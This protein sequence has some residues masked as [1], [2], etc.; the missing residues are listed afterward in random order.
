MNYSTIR[1]G[2]GKV[3]RDTSPNYRRNAD[4]VISKLAEFL[5][6]RIVGAILRFI[7]KSDL[8]FIEEIRLRSEKCVSLTADSV[9]YR[10]N[11]CCTTDEI[12]NTF[13][14]ICEKSLYAHRE[15]IKRGYITLENGVRIGICGKAS[16]D[17]EELIGVSE[18]TS[19]CIRIPHPMN[20]V[21]GEV[22]DLFNKSQMPK[23]VLIYSPPG[24]GKTTLLRGVIS[25]LAGNIP[26]YRVAV[27]DA[28]GELGYSLDRKDLCVD[29]LSGYSKAEGIEI[30]A[31]TLSA[32][33]IVC[34]E[35]GSYSEAESIIYAHSCGIPLLASAH[36][37]DINELINKP[38]INYMFKSGIFDTFV[39]I[40]RKRG[41][42]DYNYEITLGGDLHST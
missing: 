22:Y 18:V 10:L 29:I 42:F 11:V 36:A 33:I 27:V 30:A 4:T 20:D 8:S 37:S 23:G 17:H 35:I 38:A 41:A 31:R 6:S 19:L 2:D 26:P 12:M 39:G 25:K 40:S 32:Q 21:G 5:P 7:E 9:N 15:T 34:D 28:R 14:E 13:S 16:Y 24:I 3:S 1:S